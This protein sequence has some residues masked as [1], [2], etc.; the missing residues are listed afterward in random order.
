M[1]N[2]E[3]KLEDECCFFKRARESVCE[4]ERER[5]GGR[6]GE[7]EREGPL[8]PPET[9]KGIELVCCLLSADRALSCTTVRGRER[10]PERRRAER[11]VFSSHS[12]S[13]V[14]LRWPRG[15]PTEGERESGGG[16]GR[17]QK[18]RK[19]VTTL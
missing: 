14:E 19:M 7:R 10:A 9:R 18:E 6:E 3:E 13:P 4:K 1:R 8:C 5:E 16:D 11:M 17:A 2:E 12:R 15:T